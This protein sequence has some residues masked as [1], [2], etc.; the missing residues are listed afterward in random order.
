MATVTVPDPANRDRLELDLG[1]AGRLE[2]LVRA[3]GNPIAV[4]SGETVQIDYVASDDPRDPR[5]V[6]A[7]RTAAGNGIVQA[8]RGGMVPVTID[9]P[10][11][12][13]SARQVGK[14]PQMAVEVTVGGASRTMSAGESA[15]I[16][17]LTVR[18]VASTSY[19][20]DAASRVEGTPYAINLVA[21]R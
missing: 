2:L 8:R 13:L 6:M 9:V 5:D 10:L 17:G 15:V 12:M 14:A 3:G 7:L 1:Q 19:T 16:G 20:G 18:V 11:F 4:K 21:F